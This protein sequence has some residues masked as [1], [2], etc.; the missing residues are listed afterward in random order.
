MTELPEL[1][2]F[3][4]ELRF[5]LDD[6]QRR[7]CAALERGHGVLVCAPTGAGK[8]VVGEFAVHLALASGGKCFYTTPL[9]A[10]SNQKHTDLTERYGRD[11]IGLLT[12]DMSVNGDAPVVVM[13]TEVLR[14]MLYA[15]SPALQGLSYVVMDEVHFLADRMRGPVWEEVILH[16]PE[17]VRVVSLSATVSNAE[18]FGGWIQTVRGDTTVVVDEHRPVPLW[19]HVLVGKRLFDLFDYDNEADKSRVDPD[20]VRHI[21]HRREA[22]RMSDWQ[23]KRRG[24]GRAGA[25]RPRFYRPPARPDVIA[26][27]DSQGLLPAITFVFSR[28]GCDAAVQQ[29]LRSPL[30][31]TTEEERAQI[32]EVIDHRCGDLADADLAVLG[33]YEWREGLLRGLAAHH[34]GMLPAFRHTVEELFTAGLVKAVFAT[35][36][37]ALGI[38]MPARTVVLER[39]VKFNG[40]QHVPLTPGEY[41][42]LTGRAGR[43][44]IDVEG[45]AVVLWNPTEET[46]EPAAVAGLASTRTFPLRSSFAPSY[47]MTI[48][49]VQHMGPEQ[50]HQLLE[51]SF[52]QYQADR[53][54]VGLVR[55]IERGQRILDEIAAELGGR[56]A[57]IFEYARLRARIS[58]L[59]RAQS[60]ASR[61][62]RRQAATDA[63]AALRRGDIITITHGRRGG[64]AVVLESARDGDDP[65]PLVLTENRWAGR[66]SS[67]DYSGA[68]APVG[69]MSLPKRVEHRQPRVRRDLASALLSAAAGLEVPARRRAGRGDGDGTPHDPELA[70]LRAELRRHPAHNSAGLESRM[71]EAERYLRIERDNAQLEKRVGA[72]TNSLART[73]DRIVGLLTERGFIEGPATDPHVTGD[74]RLL[75]RI[76]SESDLLVAE[77]LRSGTWSGL[78]PAELA[79]V[80][81]AVLYESR[82]GDG[83]GGA[84]AAEVPTQRLRQAL[85][86]TSRLSTALRADEQAHRISPSRE[87]D[88]GFVNVI[89]RWARTGDLT[90]A[91]A[92]ADIQGV[93]SP[94][95]AGDFVRWCRQV[96]DLL[97]QVRNAA[98]DPELRAAAKRAIDDVR[99]G[100]VAVDAG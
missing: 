35:E 98:P 87:P 41:T 23:P 3:A 80:V 94:L 28:A 85:Q 78:K 53:S 16:L 64:L 22:D 84:L 32:A 70:S 75:A 56:D 24:A 61:L 27:L 20:L 59:E 71:R 34:A 52:A 83:A 49:L 11:R 30:R 96:L 45:H 37:L 21:A 89:Y 95:S 91:L 46:T 25:G 65:R 68:T 60:R 63:L 38:N 55:G 40:E 10:L 66:I 8:T 5:S 44:G 14:N 6:F 76:Y 15:D 97:D 1:A 58:E 99:R 88:D 67:A 86:Q 19:Q 33:Y 36:T 18:E 9:K 2:R 13:T 90:A 72:A 77:C 43:R 17:E 7:A 74:G 39:L 42:Q 81:S 54:V 100:V 51:Q 92:V 31:L 62:Q 26:I 93:G 12:G 57:P 29:C 82:G 79:A 48:N 50:A 4:A 73:F 69:S 47:N